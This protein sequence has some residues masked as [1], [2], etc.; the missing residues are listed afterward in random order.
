M[1]RQRIENNISYDDERKL[2]YVTFD[3]GNSTGKR[4]KKTQTFKTKREAKNALIEFQ[5]LKLK[6]EAVPDLGTMFN[7][8]VDYWLTDVKS[9]RC[10]F[11]TIYG[12]KNIIENHLKPYFGKYKLISI[13]PIIINKYIKLK[14][15]DGLSNNTVK[16]HF[17]LLNDMF[18]NAIREEVLVKNPLDRVSSIKV[19]RPKINFYNIKQMATLV[20]IVE[21]DLTENHRMEVIIKLAGM[22]GL[23]REEIAGLKWRNVNFEENYIYILEVRVQ[24]GKIKGDK[25]TKTE[26]STRVIHMPIEIKGL[27]LKVKENQDKNRELLESSYNP[28]G[29]VLAWSNGDPYRPNYLSDLFTKLIRDNNLPYI[30]LHGL[31]HS[32]ASIAN[33]LGIN[34]YSIGKALGHSKTDTTEIYTHSFDDTYATIINEVSNAIKDEVD[35][36][37]DKQKRE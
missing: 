24:A 13:T 32:F 3:Y 18:K 36:L 33:N 16:K 35:N 7:D 15:E 5:A 30:T 28:E 14:L 22:L 26:S 2:Y 6:N 21:N 9:I 4:I 1:A 19:E 10:Q 31:R 11:T 20:N 23:R 29:Y 25:V 37:K 34:L 17:N 12:Y 27:L 8:Y